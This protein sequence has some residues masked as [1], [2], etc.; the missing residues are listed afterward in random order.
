MTTITDLSPDERFAGVFRWAKGLYA[1]EAAVMLLNEHGTW[2]RRN[3]FAD[4]CMGWASV[5]EDAQGNIWID[6][7]KVEPN[8]FGG[9]GSE[10]RVLRI[11]CSL[12]GGRPIDL[13]EAVSSLDRTNLAIVLAA[14]AHANGS[15]QQKDNSWFTDAIANGETAVRPPADEP[16]LP[17]VFAWPS[18]PPTGFYRCAVCRE[19]YLAADEGDHPAHTVTMS[20]DDFYRLSREVG[21]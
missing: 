19:T 13:A 10:V 16:Y 15:H 2:L 3:D 14:I 18:D 9:S 11:A 21:S 20:P 4:R 1:Q 8:D 17:S 7:D 6:W 5:F 12:G